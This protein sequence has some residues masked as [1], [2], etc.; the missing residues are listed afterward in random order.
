MLGTAWGRWTRSLDEE[1][2]RLDSKDTHINASFSVLILERQSVDTQ[3]CHVKL[4]VY[5][6]YI[7]AGFDRLGSLGCGLK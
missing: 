6:D 7:Y 4:I 1:R 3:L 5:S 2:N